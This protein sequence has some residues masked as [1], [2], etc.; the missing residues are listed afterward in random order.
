MEPARPPCSPDATTQHGAQDR[1]Q[2]VAAAPRSERGRAT[3]QSALELGLRLGQ[4]VIVEGV[5]T[6]VEAQLARE[7]GAHLGQSYLYARPMKCDELI[8]WAAETLANRVCVDEIQVA[9]KRSR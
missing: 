4:K 6:E 3:S 8:T 5:E 2:F 9:L 7:L 1:S